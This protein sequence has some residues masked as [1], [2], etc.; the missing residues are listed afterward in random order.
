M[1][2]YVVWLMPIIVCWGTLA[3]AISVYTP[4]LAWVSYPVQWILQVAGIPEAAVTAS[5]IM[6]GFADNYLP[7]IL[8]ANLTEST[9]KVV[10]AMM[11]ILQL[12]F[13]S[14]IAT[15]L[16][17]ANALQKFSHIVIIFLQRTFIALPFVI[18]FVKLFF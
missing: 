14:E 13:L 17:S 1:M 10:I 7:V 5:A 16:T 11:S 9:S 2:F 3:L 15:L 12:I 18:V 8:G 6:S 4:L